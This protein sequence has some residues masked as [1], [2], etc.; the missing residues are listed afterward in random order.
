MES[1]QSQDGDNDLED[2]RSEYQFDPKAILEG[3]KGRAKEDKIQ[4]VV[5]TPK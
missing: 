1:Q 5:F 4:D 3:L 2:V